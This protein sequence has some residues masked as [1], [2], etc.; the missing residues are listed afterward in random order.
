M[1]KMEKIVGKIPIALWEVLSEK[2]IDVILNSSNAEQLPSGL[3]KTILFY[4]QRDQLASEAGLQKLLEASIKIEPEKT[5]ALMN[6][7][8]L[9]EVIATIVES[10]KT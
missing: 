6:E 5:I 7:L 10:M 4:W 3:A 8:G 9:G 2:L 1:G